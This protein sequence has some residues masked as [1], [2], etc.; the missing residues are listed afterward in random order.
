M[1][2]EGVKVQELYSL[3]EEMMH[4]VPSVSHYYMWCCKG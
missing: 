3:D 1:G 2:A 4:F